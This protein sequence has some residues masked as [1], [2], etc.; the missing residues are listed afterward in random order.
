[1]LHENLLVANATK[2]SRHAVYKVEI[3]APR[4]S[5]DSTDSIDARFSQRHAFASSSVIHFSKNRE[6]A[7]RLSAKD[8]ELYQFAIFRQKSRSVE[9]KGIEPLTPGLQSRCSPS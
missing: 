3:E 4:R 8:L 7:V 1:L 2:I 9:R 6:V 5:L